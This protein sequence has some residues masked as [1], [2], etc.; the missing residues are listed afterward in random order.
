MCMIKIGTT[1]ARLYAFSLLF[2][3]NFVVNF[4]LVHVDGT[5]TR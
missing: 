5:F 2:E 4:L 1:Q 3:E